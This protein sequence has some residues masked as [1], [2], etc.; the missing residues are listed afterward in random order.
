M[1]WYFSECDQRGVQACQIKGL[2]DFYWLTKRI[3]EN[4][5]RLISIKDMTEHLVEEDRSA[6]PIRNGI[7]KH[8]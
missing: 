7:G 8:R 5:L 2:G 6:S 3:S 4:Y 1:Q